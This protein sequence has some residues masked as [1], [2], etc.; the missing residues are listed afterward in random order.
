[1][2]RALHLSLWVTTARGTQDSWSWA[3]DGNVVWVPSSTSRQPGQRGREP[4]GPKRQLQLKAEGPSLRGEGQDGFTLPES[5]L[6]PAHS[7]PRGGG[8]PQGR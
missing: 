7:G 6:V 8:L 4:L 5:G 1:M 2:A 3:Q